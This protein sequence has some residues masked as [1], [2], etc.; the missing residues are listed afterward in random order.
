MSGS[1]SKTALWRVLLPILII[2]GAVAVFMTLQAFKKEPDKKEE[3]RRA[4]LVSV[5]ILE[6]ESR[7]LMVSSQG[8]FRPQY[9]TTLVAQ[10]SGE[11]IHLAPEFERGGIVKKGTLLAQIDPFNYEVQLEQAKAS[12]AAAKASLVL[13]EAQAAVAKAE[14]EKIHSSAPTDLS[15]R[16][17]QL[18]QARASVR[19]AE[20]AL[21]Q[22]EK[23]LERTQIS[24]PF[25][26]LVAERS[27]SLGTFIGTNTPLGRVLD[28]SRGEVRFPVP[29]KD[30]VYLEN[31]GMGAR[32]VILGENA[33]EARIV[34]NE[35]LIDENSRMIYLVAEVLDPYGLRS[36]AAT[37][38]AFGAYVQADIQGRYLEDI[39]SIPRQLVE[40]G[41]VALYSEGKL[42][43]RDIEILRVEGNQ[44]LVKGS[45]ESGEQIITS[46]LHYPVDGMPLRLLDA[47]LSNEASLANKES[48]SEQAL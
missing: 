40:D 20:A 8:I 27:V 17:P 41:K 44:V 6:L 22:A 39:A 19:A 18:E 33:P 12:L 2:F 15:L 31:G 42:Q 47:A 25:D 21:K 32:V 26:A 38:L 23:D 3:D 11:L 5:E 16:K 35:G 4:P 7:H 24:A 1:E 34:R 43:M 9:N 37:E 14:W 30:L 48:D 36:S 10:V 29:R 13:E 46:T 45:L 28:V